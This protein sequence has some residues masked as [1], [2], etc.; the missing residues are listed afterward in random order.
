MAGRPA[1]MASSMPVIS[2]ICAGI[3]DARV[4]E[5]G[6]R[7]HLLAVLDAHGAD[8]G[9]LG[10]AGRGPGRLE[11]DDREGDV[12]EVAALGAPVGEAD[13]HVGLPGEA[14]VA[15]HDVGDQGAHEL[16]GTVVDGEETRPDFAVVERLSGMLEESEQLIDRGER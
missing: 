1:T 5:L 2:V 10:E 4:D 11:V 3:G 12:G 13:E 9:D 8:L 16:G 7:G 6:E 15:A 14:L